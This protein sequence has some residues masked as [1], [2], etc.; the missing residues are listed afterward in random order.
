MV[1]VVAVLAAGALLTMHVY[2]AAHAEPAESREVATLS[3]Q[4]GPAASAG[5]SDHSTGGHSSHGLVECCFW[6]LLSG[7]VL[8]VAFRSF[9]LRVFSQ[10]A[11]TFTDLRTATSQRAPP[12]ATRLSLVGVSRR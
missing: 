10:I 12:L 4:A 6:L 2:T 5:S 7:L 8:F 1:A 9:R 11:R 3:T